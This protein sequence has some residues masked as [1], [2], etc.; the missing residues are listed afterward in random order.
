MKKLFTIIALSGV[1]FFGAQNEAQAQ[2]VRQLNFGIIGINYEIPVSSTITIA[3]AAGTDFDL[4]HLSLG[5]K[6]NYYLDDVFGMTDAWDA[7][8][9]ANAGYGIGLNNNGSD[10]AFGLQVG[11]RWRWSDTWGVYLEAAGGNLD[12]A[13][14]G[15]GLTMA[16]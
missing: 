16:L 12:G 13:G 2:A 14:G 15:V 4:N 3:P 7:Y 11:V 6:A 8:A 5:V 9:G 1:M 10:F